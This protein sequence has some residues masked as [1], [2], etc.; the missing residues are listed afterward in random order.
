MP[1]AWAS[2][3]PDLL[4]GY[5]LAA[6]PTQISGFQFVESKSTGGEILVFAVADSSG[7]CAVGEL[8][9][10]SAGTTVASAEPLDV[11]AGTECTGNAVMD[12]NNLY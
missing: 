6:T 8:V 4:G 5:A 9:A 10:D 11:A 3:E 12:A 1:A 7:T 2:A